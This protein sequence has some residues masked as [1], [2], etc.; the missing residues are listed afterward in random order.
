MKTFFLKAI[1]LLGVSLIFASNAFSQE[2]YNLKYRFTKGKT[3]LYKNE[4]ALNSTQEVMGQEMKFNTTSQSVLR[5]NVNN[6]EE[7]GDAEMMMSFDSLLVK[8][9]MMGRDTTLDLSNLIGKR[10]EATVTPFGKVKDY[11][12]IDSIDEKFKMMSI[13]QQASQFF[14]Q[15]AG[16]KIKEGETWN[17]SRIDTIKTMGSSIID[18][19]DFAYTLAG[20][21]SKLGHECFKIPFTTNSKMHGKGNMQGMDL[22]IE[23]TGKS[24][25]TIYFD[26]QSGIIVYS[27]TNMDNDMTMATSGQQSM[28]IPMTQSTK[29]TQTLISD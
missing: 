14:A 8:T 28:V 13:S 18:T 10:T 11:E 27:E 17:N 9:S 2:A 16:T 6:V 5:F 19:M 1:L 3:Y 23:G 20:K 22:F 4:T 26:A 24:T 7:N 29:S 12:M 21:E 25:G 15:F